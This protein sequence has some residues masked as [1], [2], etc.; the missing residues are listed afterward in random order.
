VIDSLGERLVGLARH[1]QYQVLLRHVCEAVRGLVGDNTPLPAGCTFAELRLNG[2]ALGALGKR[3]GLTA[4]APTDTC[5]RT[6]ERLWSRLAGVPGGG[7]RIEPATEWQTEELDLPAYLDRVDLDVPPEPTLDGLRTLHWAHTTKI[8]FHNLDVLL[9]RPISL[10][11]PDIQRK[12]IQGRAGGTCI[13]HSLL[14]AAALERLG[15]QVSRLAGRPR[16]GRPVVLPKTHMALLVVIN[17]DWWLVDVGLGGMGPTEPVA[18]GTGA[19]AGRSPWRWRVV[20]EGGAFVLE[21]ENRDRWVALYSFDLHQ[22]RYIDYLLVYFY[23]VTYPGIPFAKDVVAHRFST[24]ERHVAN[25]DHYTYTTAMGVRR[26]RQ[27][28]AK[29]LTEIFGVPAEDAAAVLHDRT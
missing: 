28:D 11:L 17:E 27:L 16:I 26:T 10:E 24:H 14:F 9:R 4:P 12:L 7:E 20:E 3:L 19:V 23:T 8:A 1:D 25:G 6:A 18:I 13:E 22:Q 29:T 21:T 2:A 5:S 15:F